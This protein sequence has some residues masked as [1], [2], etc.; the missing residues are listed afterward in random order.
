M[1]YSWRCSFNPILA[2]SIDI[3]LPE[4]IVFIVAL[5]IVYQ[6]Y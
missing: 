2:S 3:A 4:A 1:N 5:D 6:N